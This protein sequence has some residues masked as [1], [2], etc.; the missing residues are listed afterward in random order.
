LYEL[1]PRLA[2]DLGVDQN[3]YGDRTF[4][5][6]IHQ[7]DAP[8]NFAMG[9]Q[10]DPRAAHS[11]VVA[12]MWSANRTHKILREQTF[13]SPRT[14]WTLPA[15]TYSL[16][17]SIRPPQPPLVARGGIALY[18]RPRL[19]PVLQTIPLTNADAP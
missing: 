7:F 4:G 6:V 18:H 11:A 3:F 17:V 5:G 12:D 8:P 13:P 16:D 2:D 15:G 14:T 19:E 9:I 1:I 10:F